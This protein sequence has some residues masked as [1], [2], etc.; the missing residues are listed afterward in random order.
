MSTGPNMEAVDYFLENQ[1]ATRPRSRPFHTRCRACNR[2]VPKGLPDDG[3]CDDC[4]LL[5]HPDDRPE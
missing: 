2:F 5:E 1:A 4:R 3:I